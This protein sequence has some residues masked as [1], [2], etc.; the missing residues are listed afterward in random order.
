[1]WLSERL[2]P[3]CEPENSPASLRINSYRDPDPQ[4]LTFNTLTM[5]LIGRFCR[6]AK[7]SSNSRIL[8][9]LGPGIIDA[10]A[11]SPASTCEYD[12]IAKVN[13]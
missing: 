7:Y 3:A 1:M 6:A 9:P 12:L 5:I 8:P 10:R 13:P 4:R 11:R 2:V